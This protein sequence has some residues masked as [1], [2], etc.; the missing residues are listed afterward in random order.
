MA[1]AKTKSYLILLLLLGISTLLYLAPSLSSQ[2]I[3]FF[4]WLRN[5]N[6]KTVGVDS[7]ANRETEMDNL[8]EEVAV[9]SWKLLI[10]QKQAE[11]LTQFRQKFSSEKI[12]YA[13]PASILARRDSTSQRRSFVVDRG[14][15]DG[16]IVGSPVVS[17]NALV[18]RVWEAS[19]HVSRVLYVT[20]PLIRIGVTL[21]S[22]VK[23]KEIKNG[24]GLCIGMGKFCQLQLVEKNYQDWS[25]AEVLTSGFE[26][27]YP[28]GLYIGHVEIPRASSN[29]AENDNSINEE[30]G[31][32]WNLKLQP[33]DVDQIHTVLI[34]KLTSS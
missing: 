18:G 27:T 21:I 2:R 23:D 24:E 28:A 31:M 29:K 4:T 12:P 11:D 33:K 22:H 16:V 14:F 6:K 25:T 26:S 15:K 30:I 10:A 17:G 3:T 8:R 32:F 9:L 5:E 13:I 34:L 20:D 7:P 1:S 19:S